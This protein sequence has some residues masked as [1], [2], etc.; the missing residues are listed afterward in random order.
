MPDHPTNADN[1]ATL[2]QKIPNHDDYQLALKHAPLILFD[3]REPFFPSVVGYT[4]FR[5]S[6]ESPSFPRIIEI[7]PETA[8]VIEYAIWWDWDI[9]HLYELEHIWVHLNNDGNLIA[10]DASWH[11][12]QHPMRDENGQLPTKDGR[13]IVHSEPGKHA[14]APSP[15]WLLERQSKTTASC[16]VHAGKMGVH[17]TPIFEGVIED[18]TPLNNRL[19][20]TYLERHQFEPAYQFT[21][22]FNLEDAVF[23]PWER[24]KVW[25]PRRVNWWTKEL[26]RTIRPHE[27]RGLRIAHRGASAYAQENSAESLEV[28]AELGS[29]MVEVDIRSTADDVPVVAHDA[30]LKRLY[31]IDTNIRDVTFDELQLLT[32][33]SP[34]MSFDETVEICRSLGMGLYLDIKDLSWN[35]AQSVFESLDRHHLIKHSIFGSFRPDYLAEIKAHRPDAVTSILFNSVH[36]D[37]VALAAAIQADYVHPCWENRAPEPHELLTE[38]WIARVREADLGIVCWHEERP[39]EITALWKLGVDAICSDTPDRLLENRP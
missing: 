1:F 29:D 17:V 8:T 20:H 23:V 10:G 26:G 7:I 4:I 15:Q 37:P 13:L 3:A 14:F 35:A 25:I 6:A 12:G 9:G 39:A 31:G 24:L 30:S 2:D 5:E 28:A 19:V 27:R 21:K 11:G 16:G 22:L 33:A 32:N 36:V 34:V 38:N 18:R